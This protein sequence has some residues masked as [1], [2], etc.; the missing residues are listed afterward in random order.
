MKVTGL[1]WCGADELTRRVGHKSLK[2]PTDMADIHGRAQQVRD[3]NKPE[4]AKNG[5]CNVP[6]NDIDKMI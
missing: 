4:N 5:G 1:H 2:N 6:Y 3:Q